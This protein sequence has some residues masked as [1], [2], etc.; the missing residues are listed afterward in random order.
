[1]KMREVDYLKPF[2]NK[3]IE[4]FKEVYVKLKNKESMVFLPLVGV[5]FLIF[6]IGLL[7]F[8]SNGLLSLL[9]ILIGL[10][11]VSGYMYSATFNL[12][13]IIWILTIWAV[14]IFS[15]FS[16]IFG[17]YTEA[18][19][20]LVFGFLMVI[21]TRFYSEEHQILRDDYGNPSIKTKF[22]PSLYHLTSDI[23]FV[24]G[25]SL[26]LFSIPNFSLFLNSSS[27]V[28]NSY[29][30]LLDRVIGFIVSMGTG[31]ISDILFKGY[32]D[33]STL[34]ILGSIT[35]LKASQVELFEPNRL[36]YLTPVAM[37]LV[38]VAFLLKVITTFLKSF[39]SS[40]AFSISYIAD[41]ILYV[42]LFIGF[43]IK[44]NRDITKVLG[45]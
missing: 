39:P 29:V 5:G 26:L 8:R 15:F 19:G 14:F 43:W 7:V 3:R 36:S 44:G 18:S 28:S 41:L 1:M 6:G 42:I 32:S 31:T 17:K 2:I 34:F 37:L 20:F 45:R 21:A 16:R 22:N 13:E 38:A 4:G 23:Y 25:I 9:A 40:E 30:E 33:P 10:F 11:I 12:K 24:L 35:I 27:S